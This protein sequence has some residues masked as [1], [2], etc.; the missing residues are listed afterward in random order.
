MVGEA[1]TTINRPFIARLERH[2]GGLAAVIANHVIHL[3]G[4]IPLGPPVGP[5]IPA[6]LGF[7]LKPLL[8]EELLLACG[9]YEFVPAILAH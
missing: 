4:A 2:L 1:I 9:K 7:V 8:R 3:T 5:A 6:P